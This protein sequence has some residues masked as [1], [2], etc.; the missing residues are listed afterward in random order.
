RIRIVVHRRLAVDRIRNHPQDA[1]LERPDAMRL[2]RP[3]RF[4]MLALAEHGVVSPVGMIAVEV[5]D[6][7]IVRFAHPVPETQEGR[8]RGGRGR[9][10]RGSGQESDSKCRNASERSHV[11]A[12][13]AQSGNS[14]V[15]TRRDTNTSLPL[16]A[17]MRRSISVRASTV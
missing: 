16:P 3:N 13:D 9:W 17:R 14:N 5:R 2:L 7:R 12:P 11:Y 1:V 4:A 15:A 8:I 6:T 10:R